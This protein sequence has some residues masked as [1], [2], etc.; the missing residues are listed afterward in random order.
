[1]ADTTTPTT[2]AERFRVG[3]R[4]RVAEWVAHG[5]PRTPRYLR[6]REGV[7]T[8]RWGIIENPLDHHLPYPPLYTVEFRLADIGGA[9]GDD[10]VTADLHD[11]WLVGT[12][13]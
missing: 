13:S 12:E 2:T 7:V 6:G 11:E 5:N 1:M 3:D 10:I 8:L 9:A 4:V